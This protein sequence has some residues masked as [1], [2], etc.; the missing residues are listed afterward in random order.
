[1]HNFDLAVGQVICYNEHCR[2]SE[3]KY[4]Q[5][6]LTNHKLELHVRRRPSEFAKL[7]TSLIRYC[8][9][10]VSVS[11]WLHIF[12]ACHWIAERQRIG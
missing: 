10:V 9:L 12:L 7:A 3:P 1:M 11:G 6:L 2:I 8:S 5:A 4:E